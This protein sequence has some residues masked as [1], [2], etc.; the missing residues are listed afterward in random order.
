MC[1]IVYLSLEKLSRMR[2]I[3]S[4]VDSDQ[5]VPAMCSIT[6]LL[7]R[8]RAV[9]P[10]QREAKRGTPAEP[11]DARQDVTTSLGDDMVVRDSGPRRVGF[12][13]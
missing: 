8:D 10:Q 12:A 2:I 6:S 4:W 11:I 9:H 5:L 7:Q 3:G 13:Q 1:Y